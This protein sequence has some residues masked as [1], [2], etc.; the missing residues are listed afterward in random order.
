MTPFIGKDAGATRFKQVLMGLVTILGL[1]MSSPVWA[2]GL[3]LHEAGTPDLGTASAGRTAL[4]ADASTAG[5]NPAG[6]TRLDRSQM[7]I[8][9]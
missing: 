2:G 3:W 1:L 8:A 7:L 4:A 5:I 6:M 9:A